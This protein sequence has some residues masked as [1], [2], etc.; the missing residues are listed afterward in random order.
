MTEKELSDELQVILRPLAHLML[1][2]KVS[3]SDFVTASTRAFVDVAATEAE[4][5]IPGRKQTAS[6]ISILTGINRKTVARFLDEDEGSENTVSPASQNRAVRVIS[7]WR[8]NKEYV[9]KKG[10]PKPL[11]IGEG[12]REGS[13]ENLVKSSSGGIT[14]RAI[15]DELVSA[16]TVTVNADKV[17]LNDQGYIPSEKNEKIGLGYNS[18]ADLISTVIHNITND[19]VGSDKYQRSVVYDKVSES[20]VNA[21]KE[22]CRYESSE[23]LKKLNIFLREYDRDVNPDIEDNGDNYRAGIGIYFTSNK[24]DK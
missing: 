1:T 7:H 23:L 19:N 18:I 24:V 13:F 20:G 15:L 16:G 2:N 12:D 3:Y 21:F 8:Y 6:R 4:F 11:S 9:D 14:P 22:I 10:K 17:S 5:L